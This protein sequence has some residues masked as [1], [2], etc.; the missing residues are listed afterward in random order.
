MDDEASETMRQWDSLTEGQRH[1]K[2][3]AI[4]ALESL[5]LPDEPRCRVTIVQDADY[6]NPVVSIVV[7]SSEGGRRRVEIHEDDGP[8]SLA[9]RVRAAAEQLITEGE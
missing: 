1:P 4:L 7:E 8:C 3:L 2:N 5:A 9:T 6:W